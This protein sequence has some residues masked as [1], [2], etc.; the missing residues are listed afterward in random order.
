MIEGR[1]AATVRCGS[2]WR[3]QAASP[4][5]HPQP[6]IRRSTRL[7]LRRRLSVLAAKA[8]HDA[9]GRFE[10]GGCSLGCQL[11]QGPRQGSCL[12][13]AAPSTQILSPSARQAFVTASVGRKGTR[14]PACCGAQAKSRALR[15][16]AAGMAAMVSLWRPL[17]EA[18]ILCCGHPFTRRLF[19][20]GSS[21]APLTLGRV[22]LTSDTIGLSCRRRGSTA[23]RPPPA[24]IIDRSRNRTEDAVG[25]DDGRRWALSV[26]LRS[27]RPSDGW[28]A[29]LRVACGVAS[30]VLNVSTLMWMRTTVRL[31]SPPLPSPIASACHHRPP[32]LPTYARGTTGHCR[33]RAHLLTAAPPGS[34]PR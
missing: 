4:L 10:A 18:K 16:G 30:Q 25:G 32:P 20:Y 22:P 12:G 14:L 29:G 5:T 24:R 6:E 19:T 23:G 13:R 26:A 3:Q 33:L 1:I 2:T 8:R 7:L 9:G 27:R 21:G 34:L 28:L 17:N 31:P 15:G 11:V